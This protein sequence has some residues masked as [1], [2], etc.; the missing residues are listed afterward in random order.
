ME[1][2]DQDL[3]P[4]EKNSYDYEEEW[5]IFFTR[6]DA[7]DFIKNHELGKH[8]VVVKCDVKRC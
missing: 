3:Y 5:R 6:Q 7:R 2:K 4:V 8:I 1:Y